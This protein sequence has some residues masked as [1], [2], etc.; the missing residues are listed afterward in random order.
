MAPRKVRRGLAAVILAAVGGVTFA[1]VAF[2]GADGEQPPPGTVDETPSE[3]PPLG[4][5]PPPGTRVAA[6]EA[7]PALGEQPPNPNPDL[8]GP[9]TQVV[10]SEAEGA[11]TPSPAGEVETAVVGQP[12]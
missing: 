11:G 1:G 10:G 5:Q 2:V 3:A 7:A 8:S 6:P 4:T 9:P 12:D